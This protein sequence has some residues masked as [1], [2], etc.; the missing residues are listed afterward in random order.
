MTKGKIM[1]QVLIWQMLT[2]G[3]GNIVE[4]YNNEPHAHLFIGFLLAQCTYAII[5][6]IERLG[7][8]MGHGAY[9]INEQIKGLRQ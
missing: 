5:Q 4:I 1:K 8:R 3:L 7:D 2:L 6:T 9:F